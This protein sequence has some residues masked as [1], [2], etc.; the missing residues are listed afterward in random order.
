M[1]DTPFERV[2]VPAPPTPH[3][4]TVTLVITDETLLGGDTGPGRIPV[5]SIPASVARPIVSTVSDDRSGHLR[6]L[7]RHPKSGTWWPWSRGRD[8]FRRA[9]RCSSPCA[10]RPAAR[11]TAMRPSD[12]TTTPSPTTV[13]SPTSALNG[14]GECER[15]NYSK[16]SPGWRVTT[17]DERYAYSRIRHPDRS[18]LLVDRTAGAEAI[19]VHLCEV[20][21]RVG[22]SLVDRDAA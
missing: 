17:V 15:C 21:V 10:T 16:E 20:E 1:A 8:S 4:V 18:S 22:I 11:R 19:Q 13:D 6:R 9:W 3:P 2:T 5:R 14:L 12:T 7:Y